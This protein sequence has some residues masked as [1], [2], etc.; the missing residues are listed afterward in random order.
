[1]SYRKIS[2]KTGYSIS[3]ISKV[4]SNNYEISDIARDRI[5]AAAREL[6]VFDKYYKKQYPQKIV[7]VICPELYSRY[8]AAFA[9]TIHAALCEKNILTIMSSTGFDS[10]A[11]ERLIEYYASYAKVDGIIILAPHISKIKNYSIPIV[12]I[13][14]LDGVDSVYVSHRNAIHDALKLLINGGHQ[15]IAFIG[16]PLTNIKER[17]FCEELD[18]LMHKS[19][20]ELIVRSRSRFEKAGYA[21]METLL[22]L[23]V[24]PTAVIAGYD[25]IAMGAMECAKAHNFR[26]PEDISII[27]MDDI[28]DASYTTPPLASIKTH[29]KEIAA[30]TIDMIMKK[31][32]HPAFKIIQR[33]E[34]PAEFIVRGSV[35]ARQTIK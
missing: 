23:S 33:T 1:M 32:E 31:I 14:K 35:A 34:V 20:P 18:G 28:D 22:S 11:E 9:E 8:Y 16:E 6:G 13:G 7:A 17:I 3:T 10:A 2:E 12:A 27:G 15:R 26:I 21:G 5:Y 29:M 30:L 24:P 25:Y 4:F 19:A